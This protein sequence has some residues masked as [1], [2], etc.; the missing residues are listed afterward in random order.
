[1]LAAA[2]AVRRAVGVAGV[3]SGRVAGLEAAIRFGASRAVHVSAAVGQKAPAKKG[4]GGGAAATPAFVEEKVDLKVKIPV[5]I[6]KDGADPEYKPDSEYPPWLFALLEEKPLLEDYVMRGLE[7][8]KG[9][10]MKTVAR[11]ANKK[12]ILDG[13]NARRKE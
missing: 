8:V 10:E 3:A 12:R 2:R 1:M 13:N 4:G 11:L 9:R 7:H 5:N 6:A